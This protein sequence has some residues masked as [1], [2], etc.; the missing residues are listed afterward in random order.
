M[1][2]SPGT[3]A[4]GGTGVLP[5]DWVDRHQGKRA[6]GGS[7]VGNAGQ[8]RERKRRR[9][10]GHSRRWRHRRSHVRSGRLIA[11]AHLPPGD[12]HRRRR[13]AARR[14]RTGRLGAVGHPCEP[15][16]HTGRTG[17]GRGLSRG[18][19]SGLGL[20]P[21]WS[22]R[23]ARG[24]PEPRGRRSTPR[25]RPQRPAARTALRAPEPAAPAARAPEPPQCRLPPCRAP[26][27]S[28]RPRA[29]VRYVHRPDRYTSPATLLSPAPRSEL[30][31]CAGPR[32]PPGVSS[33]PMRTGPR[34]ARRRRSWPG[35][36]PAPGG[37]P[38]TLGRRR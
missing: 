18:L 14:L 35:V 17:A 30:T 8:E 37:C 13:R 20:R 2:L 32:R 34:P 3:G 11:R 9:R 16:G 7:A 36:A 38:R 28:C 23:P 27:A 1:A 33:R 5:S 4:G 6:A 10:R 31:E 15:R 29:P 19:P 22:L 26:A 25:R 12:G 21:T 24:G